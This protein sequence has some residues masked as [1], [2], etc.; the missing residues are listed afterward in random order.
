[1]ARAMQL[2]YAPKDL[3][4]WFSNLPYIGTDG[5]LTI[6]YFTKAIKDVGIHLSKMEIEGL[7]HHLDVD[8]TG[9]YMKC[10]ELVNIYISTNSS[11]I[12]Y[13]CRINC[14]L[15][16]NIVMP[17]MTEAAII[18]RMKLLISKA[19]RKG[20]DYHQTLLM[21]D[22]SKKKIVSSADFRRALRIFLG[23]SISE[24]EIAECI[25][26][27]GLGKDS[28]INYERFLE[29]LHKNDATT[30]FGNK[31]VVTHAAGASN[32]GTGITSPTSSSSMAVATAGA[33]NGKQI[34]REIVDRLGVLPREVQSNFEALDLEGTGKL[35]TA[36]FSTALKKALPGISET[37]VIII[38]KY[39]SAG[40]EPRKD[41]MFVASSHDGNSN[42]STKLS[43]GSVVSYSAVIHDLNDVSNKGVGNIGPLTAGLKSWWKIES[44]RVPDLQSYFAKKE[45]SG[46]GSNVS[47]R[48]FR[49][50]L[51]SLAAPVHESEWM[52][53][54]IE[55][56]L[57]VTAVDDT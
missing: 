9:R 52:M 39:Y 16:C 13:V 37:D 33:R 26:F 47:R 41:V 51:I 32:I 45:G 48:T 29:L 11:H 53:V 8:N 3:R 42:G 21:F 18:S 36:L 4:A 22:T 24:V 50:G 28:S 23:A 25:D 10:T 38:G 2:P 7:L 17:Q 57:Y 55:S 1:M 44:K 54:R 34:L 14:Q 27:L 46:D 35:T 20:L 15:F 49:E 43:V 5:T 31:S 6:K 19:E 12:I 56:V 30:T 40:S